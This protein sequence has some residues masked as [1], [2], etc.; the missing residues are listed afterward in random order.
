M[1]RNGGGQ[2]REGV[3]MVIMR[4]VCSLG[5]IVTACLAVIGCSSSDDFEVDRARCTQLRDHM[6]DLRLAD[7][8][9]IV[10]SELTQHRTAMN[11][12]L[13]DR[14]VGECQASLSKTELRC[15][16]AAKTLSSASDCSARSTPS[17]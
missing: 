1:V 11:S 6:V 14:F 13:G 16:L 5:W 10:S 17:K 9:G 8:S 12:A 15:S 4:S 3:E 7:A 2:R